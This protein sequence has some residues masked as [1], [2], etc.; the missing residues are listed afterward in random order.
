MSKLHVLDNLYRNQERVHGESFRELQGINQET[1]RQKGQGDD[2]SRYELTMLTTVL[3]GK[4]YPGTSSAMTLIAS[5]RDLCVNAE[6]SE[7]NIM[8]QGLLVATPW[9][10]KTRRE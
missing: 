4:T 6:K 2:T 8:E 7:G 3:P 1:G 9:R 5:C 10:T